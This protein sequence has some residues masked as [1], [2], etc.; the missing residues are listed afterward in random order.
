MQVQLQD[1]DAGAGCRRLIDCWLELPVEYGGGTGRSSIIVGLWKL[2]IGRWQL[3]FGIATGQESQVDQGM[4]AQNTT[5]CIVP[6][7]KAPCS[8]AARLEGWHLH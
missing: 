6:V 2:G 8:A 1:A 7:N 4:R 5:Y 3:D